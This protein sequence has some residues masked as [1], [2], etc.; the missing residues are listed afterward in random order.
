MYFISTGEFRGILH[1]FR[2]PDLTRIFTALALAALG[3]VL[4]WYFKNGEALYTSKHYLGGFS[5]LHCVFLADSAYSAEY[6]QNGSR[7]KTSRLFPRLSGLEFL[8]LVKSVPP[9]LLTY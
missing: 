5:V 1:F 9:W 3:L 8:A 2:L 7:E 6:M 4:L